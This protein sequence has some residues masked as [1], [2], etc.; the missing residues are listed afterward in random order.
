MSAIA[1]AVRM[2]GFAAVPAAALLA[3]SPVACAIWDAPRLTLGA[4]LLVA[5][6]YVGLASAPGYSYLAYSGARSAHLGLIRRWWV[7]ASL[8]GAL[9]ASLGGIWGGTTVFF[10]LPPSLISAVAV[11]L[12]WRPFERRAGTSD[13]G[14]QGPSR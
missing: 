12:L 13:P 14:V 5:P 10:L 9:A 6:F 2:V 3:A 7:R 1:R 8:A 11:V 4:A